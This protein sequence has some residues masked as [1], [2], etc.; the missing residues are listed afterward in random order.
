MEEKEIWT[1]S[2][3]QWSNFG[4][5]LVCVPL[6]FF[7][8]IG[9]AVAIWKYLTTKF[10]KYEITDQR[11]IEHKGILSKTTDELEL[12]RVKDVRHDQ[13]FLLGLFGLSNVIL[14]TTDRSHGHRMDLL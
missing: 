9:V 6:T 2:P 12:Y 3:S 7:F 13:P 11:I 4:V 5:Y 1:G 10:H 8:G 14:S